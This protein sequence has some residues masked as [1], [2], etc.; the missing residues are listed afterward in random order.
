MIIK[1]VSIILYLIQI[2][3]YVIDSESFGLCSDL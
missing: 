1:L 2:I 3:H